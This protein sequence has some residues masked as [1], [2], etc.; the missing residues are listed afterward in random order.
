[1]RKSNS[2]SGTWAE[3][4]GSLGDV[5]KGEPGKSAYEIAVEHGFEGTEEEW[6][7]YVQANADRAVSAE[8]AA[9]EAKEAAQY[10]SDEAQGFSESASTSAGVAHTEAEAAAESAARA[11]AAAVSAG[12]SRDGVVMSAVDAADSATAAAAS[13]TEAASQ[14]LLATGRA[15]EARQSQID[16]HVSEV[17][18]EEMWLAFKRSPD[19][20]KQYAE[21]AAL[22]AQNAADS[23]TAAEGYKEDT[24]GLKLEIVG[25]RNETARLCT[26]TGVYASQADASAQA[27][28]ASAQEA[29]ASAEYVSQRIESEVNSALSTHL[30]GKLD[31]NG[32]AV[33]SAHADNADTVNNHTVL[34]DVPA[35]A[36]FTDT[37][38][39]TMTAAEAT[40]GT[41][42]T[43]RVITA[44]VLA[45]RIA[46]AVASLVN[47]SP[48]TLDTLSELATALGN[49]PNFATTMATALGNKL[50]KAGGVVTGDLT[51]NG[52]LTADVTGNADTATKLAT[53]RTINIQDST[54]TNTGTGASFDGT[55]N[56]TIK[57]PATIKAN[58]TGNVTGSSGSCTGNA[59]TATSATWANNVASYKMSNLTKGTNPSST[60]WPHS[61]IRCDSA[62]MAMANRVTELR[63]FVDINGTVG[64]EL[65]AYDFASG[66]T[67]V[68]V[69]GVYKEK[70]G[71]AYATAPTP[72]TADNS[73][74][75]ATTAWVRTAT[76]NTSLNA[77]TATKINGKTIPVV[78]SFNSTTGVLALTSLS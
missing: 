61:W 70:G 73:N 53:A 58:I 11:E 30:A 24:E 48:A 17:H 13:A 37:T 47:S 56:A 3:I 25:Y 77:A 15:D 5:T 60:I 67:D 43:A 27:A 23:E 54:A 65:L 1:M 16:A 35:N 8:S 18:C 21:A 50:D 10:A 42:T 22:S 34:S 66:G 38:Y 55:G 40:T 69:L 52:T 4:Y 32:K 19:L 7:S 20:A 64:N 41:G 46:E 63:S 28:A 57:L 29:G 72:A 62:G 51:V 6:L 71:A 26:Q 44:K 59:A 45:D 74:M 39:D 49:D 36:V 68:A 2:N 75:I 9:V 33:D 12:E 31:V 78:S 14:A 76:G